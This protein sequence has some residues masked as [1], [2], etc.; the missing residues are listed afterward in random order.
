[1]R[2]CARNTGSCD[3]PTIVSLALALFAVD[4]DIIVGGVFDFDISRTMGCDSALILATGSTSRDDTERCT[5][6]PM[7]CVSNRA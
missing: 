5:V 3:L 2:L 7:V 6:Q 4:L 1:M